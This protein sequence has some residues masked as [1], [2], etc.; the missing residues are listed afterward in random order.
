MKCIIA[1]F[2]CLTAFVS[3]AQNLHL[4]IINPAQQ[5]VPFATVTLFPEK[6][7]T[8]KST[9]RSDAAGMTNFTLAPGTYQARV[10][11]VG[12]ININQMIVVEQATELT[13]TLQPETKALKG[14]TIV[15]SKPLVR[16][17]DDKTIVDP[18]PLV[19]AST[20]AYEL[21]E[22]TPGVFADQNGNVFLSSTSA[23]A[24]FINGREQRMSAADIATM[25]K[26]LPPNAI[27]SI[28][29]LRTPS[30]RYDAS[31]GGGIINIILKKGVRIGMTG[32]VN[33]GMNQGRYGNQFAGLTLN[34]NN[35]KWSSFANL[36]YNHRNNY[37]Q[38]NT[39]RV[40]GG[41]TLLR[42]AARTS[43]PAQSVYA[44]FG[45]TFSPNKRVDL[46]YDGRITLNQSDNRS[47]NLSVIEAGN[48]K[49]QLAK[50]IA[51][52]TTG[53][54][55][56]VLV[57]GLSAKLKGR[58]EGDE[59]TTDLSYTLLPSSLHQ[60]F[61]TTYLLPQR[62]ALPA[63]G[64]QERGVQ[65][66]QAQTNLVHKI[67]GG[68]RLETGLKTTNIW[69]DSKADFAYTINGNMVPD[70]LRTN[71]YRYDEHIHAG[72]LQGSK[73]LKG[74]VVKAGARVEHTRME[75]RQQVPYDTAFRIQRTDAFPY[76][77]L[78]RNL[79]RIAGYDLKAYLV[80][81]RTINRPAYE[82]LN[83][84][85]KVIDPYL[86]ESGNPALRPQFT[87]NFEANVSVDERPIIAVGVNNTK[88]IF[89]QVV[90][91]ADTSSALTYRTYDNLGTNKEI[92]FRAL[93]AIPPGKRYFF[94]AG[95]QYNHNLYAG[96]YETKPL[97]F[98]RA[99]WTVFTFHSFKIN[100]LTTL[101]MNGFARFKGQLQ[102][103]ELG[104]F[105]A[106]NFSLNRQLLQKKMTLGFSINDVFFTNNNS[107][108]LRQGSINAKGYRENDSRRFGIT[109]RYNFG[110]RKKEENGLMNMMTAEPNTTG[111]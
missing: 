57:Q 93:G 15:A 72:Y 22:K 45:T 90:Y 35:R 52:V 9:N 98:S 27:A 108:V 21:L 68:I 65:Q 60:D 97:S 64:K 111:N 28:E 89:S 38:L 58:K 63:N 3:S 37:E 76:V 85:P 71:R 66:F 32:S 107:F 5:P 4:K 8:Q 53:N 91:Q 88:D 31:G 17:E 84:A 33:L 42:Q 104:S 92:Y 56:L 62:P 102:F 46:S 61:L 29:V 75:G 48:T 34:N 51:D 105:G 40:F 74:I 26:S 81:R 54:K 12:Y 30:A 50:N 82:Y 59:W 83:P 43:Y 7:S 20:N 6:D 100:K 16:Q 103:Y 25:L 13:L 24:I 19:P 14:V 69:L 10:S 36:Q 39:D 41:D 78:S 110:L 101:N 106:L 70:K 73:N 79:M 23:A 55:G 1:A 49:N 99:S 67:A 80:Y 2:F 86:Y 77:Y 11:S 87:Q 95:V 96:L 18:E 44:A 47:T 94:V 109:L